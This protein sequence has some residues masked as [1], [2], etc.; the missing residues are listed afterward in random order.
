MIITHIKYNGC[1]VF[2]YTSPRKVCINY[3]V[4]CFLF[5]CFVP[6]EKDYGPRST[7]IWMTHDTE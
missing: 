6:H 3:E 2:V 4:D 7:F 1:E 5:L